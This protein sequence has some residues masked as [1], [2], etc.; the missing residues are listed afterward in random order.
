MGLEGFILKYTIF[1]IRNILLSLFSS[2][3]RLPQLHSTWDEKFVTINL[4]GLD[5]GYSEILWSSTSPVSSE[6]WSPDWNKVMIVNEMHNQSFRP[7]RAKLFPKSCNNLRCSR[8]FSWKTHW[9]IPKSEKA[10]NKIRKPIGGIF[11]LNNL[12]W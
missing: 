4:I 1:I 12:N 2:H 11:Y 6:R 10:S 5:E 7:K 8:I 3:Q 9:K